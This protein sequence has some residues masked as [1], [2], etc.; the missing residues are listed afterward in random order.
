MFFLWTLLLGIFLAGKFYGVLATR[1]PPS[2]WQNVL[3]TMLILLG[4]AVEDSASGKDVYKA[5]AVRMGLFLLITLY[6]WMALIFLEWLRARSSNRA[7][8]ALEVG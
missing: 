1:Y 6:A 7:L 5:F 4:P 8:R 3:V 2:F